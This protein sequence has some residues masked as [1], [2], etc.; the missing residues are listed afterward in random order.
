VLA[1]ILDNDISIDPDMSRLSDRGVRELGQDAAV[2]P[3]GL[4][5][6]T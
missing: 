4:V 6:T 3:T 2:K 1:S 5:L